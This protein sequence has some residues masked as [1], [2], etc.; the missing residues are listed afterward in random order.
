M[1]TEHAHEAFLLMR[2]CAGRCLVTYTMRLVGQH[3]LWQSYDKQFKALCKD[4]I[5]CS[6][7]LAFIQSKHGGLGLLL[8][9]HTAASACLAS[10]LEAE[11]A[12]Q[13]A[14]NKEVLHHFAADPRWIRSSG[15]L[16]ALGLPRLDD[17]VADAVRSTTR[18]EK[19]QHKCVEVIE[20][21]QRSKLIE[22]LTPAQEG[23]RRGSLQPAAN[24]WLT[25]LVQ[26][27]SAHFRLLV[28]HRFL[29][30]ITATTPICPQC[31]K[32][33]LDQEGQH[34]LSCM[35]S[36]SRTVLHSSLC[37]SI[38]QVASQGLLNATREYRPQPTISDLRVDIALRDVDTTTCFDVAIHN[39]AW[40]AYPASPGGAAQRYEK[41]K[42]TKYQPLMTD[43]TVFIP[44]VA[45]TGFCW[46]PS[47]LAALRSSAFPF[48][49]D[50]G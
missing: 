32:V 22:S 41:V 34:I 47:A 11:K 50:S 44:L 35:T 30:P 10:T 1:A 15:A 7:P 29:Q 48:L 37:K 39:P 18:T 46:S 12:T 26:L 31:R 33:T 17:I 40:P 42:N 38:A 16:N 19:L 28:R 9:E 24:L 3:P 13:M 20:E 4:I 25:N 49:R 14:V 36:G 23:R 5:S 43:S 21:T 6:P 8:S 45:E 27:N 2:Q